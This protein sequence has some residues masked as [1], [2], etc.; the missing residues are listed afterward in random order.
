[1]KQQNP[2]NDRFTGWR[3]MFAAWLI[4]IVTW[5]ILYVVPMIT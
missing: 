3:E 1:M 4:V 5:V 2:E